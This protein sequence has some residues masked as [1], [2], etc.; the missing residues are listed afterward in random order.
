MSLMYQCNSNYIYFTLIIFPVVSEHLCAIS[1]SYK[2]VSCALLI[3]NNGD[4]RVKIILLLYV[5][6]FVY[7]RW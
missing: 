7:A 1:V 3:L 5:Q 6:F 2:G 4:R